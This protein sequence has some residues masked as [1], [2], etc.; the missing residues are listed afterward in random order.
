MGKRRGYGT[1]R[2][3]LRRAPAA[4]RA[5]APAFTCVT[6]LTLALG[7]GATTAIF[8]AVNPILFEPLP[9]PQAARIAMISDFG[10]NGA[11]QDVTFGTHLELTARAR[12]FEAI[13]VM[14]PWQPT[15]VGEAEP[16]R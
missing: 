15:M 3:A 8:S 5:G 12:T 2:P 13:A 6:L 14:K 11:P 1:H 16:E 10:P 7:I 4:R 9:Y